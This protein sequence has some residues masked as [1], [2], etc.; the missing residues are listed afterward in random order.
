MAEGVLGEIVARKRIDVA[1]RLAGQDLAS[2]RAR[3]EPTRRSLRTALARSGARFVMEVKRSSPSQGAL[4][5]AADPA[6]IA[7]AYS[8]AADAVSVLTDGPFFGGTLD[9]LAAVRAV[10]DGPILAKDFIVDARQVAEA[11]LHG[12]DAVLVILAVLSDEAARTAIAEAAALG[13]D[14]LVEAHDEAEVRRAVALEAPLV[15]INNRDLKTLKVDLAATER[16]SGLVPADRLVVAESGIA[17]RADVERLA[18]HADAFLVGSSLMRAADP[19]LAARALA[20]G[21]VKVCGLTDPAD[22]AAAASGASFAG[23]VMVP[24]TPRAVTLAAAERIAKA[25]EL[26]VVGVFRNEKPMQVA[27]AAL[28]LGLAAVQLHGEEDALYIR[29]LRSLLRDGTEIWAAGAVAETVPEP[30]LGADR[31]LYDT[32]VDGRSGGTGT[33][34]DWSRLAGRPE[35]ESSILAGGL[36]PGNARAAAKVGAY[37][38]DVG[39]GVEAAPGRKDPAKLVA[40]FEALRLPVRGELAR[41]SRE[42]GNPAS[43]S[44][45][46]AVPKRDP[47]FRGGDEEVDLTQC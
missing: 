17:D 15:G 29:G 44:S 16:L 5:S 20:F 21:R 35:L 39:S 46:D 38:L 19:G 27:E 12:A 26:P 23:L 36:N 34:F 40:F 45:R 11:R 1:A 25:S 6:A 24:G 28:R 41:H 4:R 22:A 18:P 10:F 7:R 9:D 32:T 42:S 13:M 14:V 43:F 2:L 47:P 3:A 33:A 30:R 37:A 8:G 31:A